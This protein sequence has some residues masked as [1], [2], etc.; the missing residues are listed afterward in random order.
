MTAHTAVGIDNDFTAGNAGVGRRPAN[1]P[2]TGTVNYKMAI[3]LELGYT[4]PIN[5]GSGIGY[6]IK[7]IVEIILSNMEKKPEVMWDTSKPSG[8]KK[9]LMDISR[10]K[11]IGWS[12]NIS[13]AEGIKET[14]AWYKENKGSLD[15]RY[16]V[17]TQ[18]AKSI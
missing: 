2:F 14:M 5:L 8:D 12:P 4:E 13:L 6:T 18:Q 11:S 10:A 16:N 15:K 17:F 3:A 9:R 7:E 1:N